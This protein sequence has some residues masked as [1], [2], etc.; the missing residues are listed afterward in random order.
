MHCKFIYEKKKL[1]SLHFER[2]HDE[3]VEMER[4]TKVKIER[5][6]SAIYYAKQIS[7]IVSDLPEKELSVFMRSASVFD[8]IV[9]MYFD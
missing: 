6:I 2:F 1:R 7:S 3:F 5:F 9:M 8:H 4:F